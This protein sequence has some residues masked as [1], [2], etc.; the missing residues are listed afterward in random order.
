MLPAALATMHNGFP[1]AGR[2]VAP[3]CLLQPVCILWS[4]GGSQ[5]CRRPGVSRP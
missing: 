5:L 3:C 1:R 4:L 2:R